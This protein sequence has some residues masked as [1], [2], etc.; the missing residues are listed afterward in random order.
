[1]PAEPTLTAHPPERRRRSTI[2]LASACSCCCCCC[3]HA[4][5]SVAGAVFGQLRGRKKAADAPGEEGAR[6]LVEIQA[7]D[8]YATKIY[9]LAIAIIAVIAVFV[10]VVESRGES[11]S[12]TFWICFFTIALG[13]PMG[14]LGASVLSLIYIN[15][16]PPVRKDVCL[17]RLGRITLHAFVGSIIGGAAM[18]PFLFLLK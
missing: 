3:V 14:Q 16:F 6:G 17:R 8:R 13:L 9:W 5:G 18:V 7:A 12:N 1:M 11:S 2:L 15:V 4:L 10:A